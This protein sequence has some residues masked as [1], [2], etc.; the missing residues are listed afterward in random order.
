MKLLAIP[1]F[2]NRVSPRLDYAESL[3]LVT[4]CKK[5]IKSIET[6]KI[7]AKNNLWRGCLCATR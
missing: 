3:K 5:E 1:N 4:I 6:V 2:G 7:L